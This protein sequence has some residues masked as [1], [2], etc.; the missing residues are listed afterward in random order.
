MRFLLDTDTC[1]WLLRNNPEVTAQLRKLTPADVALSAMNDA[2]LRDGALNS[3]DPA[4]RT[5]DVESSAR[6]RLDRQ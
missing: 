1:I 4:R 6:P 2:E 5:H 3:Q